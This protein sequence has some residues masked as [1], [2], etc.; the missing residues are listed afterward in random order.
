MSNTIIH[1]SDVS[2]VDTAYKTITDIW[3]VFLDL[4]KDRLSESRSRFW[5]FL[6]PGF[7]HVECWKFIYPGVWIRLD[8]SVELISVDVYED[9]PWEAMAYLNPTVKHV[10]RLVSK[11]PWRAKFFIG[12]MTC[13]ELSKAFLGVSAFFVRTPFQLY[14]FL[15]GE[16]N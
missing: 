4:D 8:T 13:V 7:Q 10:R 16:D 14:N 12:P 15:R 9:P 11:G 1:G 6:K 5:R 3:V 2:L